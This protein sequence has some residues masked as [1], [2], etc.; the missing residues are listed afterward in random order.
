MNRTREPQPEAEN[1]GLRERTHAADSTPTLSRYFSYITE[2]ESAV[3]A[4]MS[5]CLPAKI[6]EMVA[7]DTAVSLAISSCVNPIPIKAFSFSFV[8]MERNI[9]AR[10]Y[11]SQYACVAISKIYVDV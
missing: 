7:C 11:T 1:K 6:R 5:A 10:V 8:F 2:T 3:D 4:L 9:Y